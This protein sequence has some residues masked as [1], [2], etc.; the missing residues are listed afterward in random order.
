M[1]RVTA[2]FILGALLA[3]LPSARAASSTDAAALQ[4]GGRVGWGRL[5]TPGTQWG[6]HGE[7]DPRLTRFIAAQTALNLDQAWYPVT[8]DKLEQLCL[9]PFL[10][11]KDLLRVSSPAH[12]RNL[13]EY[14][15]RGGFICI[16]PCVNGYSPSRKEDLVRQY[17]KL[18][19]RLFP[20]SVMRD[21][22]DEHEIYRC[23]FPVTVDGLYTP[24]MIR[25][26]AIKPSRIGMRGVFL[27]ERMIAVVSITGLECG[28]PE[29]P[30][31]VPACLQMITN[32]YV[33]AMTR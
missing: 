8:A 20:D 21:L 12:L 9:Y 24:D 18:F 5:I 16:D 26:G 3:T 14:V 10:F 25:A 31:R 19:T 33:Y 11:T 2:S 13:Q 7:Q 22:P 32:V 17:E 27:G 4:H 6:R 23:Y 28:W 30:D 1:N 29:T 15:R